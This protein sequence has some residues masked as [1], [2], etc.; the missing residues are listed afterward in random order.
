METFGYTAGCRGCRAVNRSTTEM[1]HAEKCRKQIAEELEKVGSERLE[2]ENERLSERLKEEK[3]KQ[4]Q[5]KSGE[6]AQKEKNSDI[7]ERR[8]RN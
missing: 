4:K 5:A 3:N 8:G 6:S 7:I 1:K 2:R